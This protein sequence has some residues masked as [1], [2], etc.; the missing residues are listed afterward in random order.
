M[1]KI[2]Y[3]IIKSDYNPSLIG[4]VGTLGKV[5]SAEN[6]MFYPIEG[7]HPYRVCLPKEWVKEISF[8]TLLKNL[9]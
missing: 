4:R 1:K 5:K 7:I 3:Q 6:V 2:F 9:F 8:N